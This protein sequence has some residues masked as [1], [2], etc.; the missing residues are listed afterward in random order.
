[1]TT[2]PSKPFWMVY[3]IRQGAPT[4]MH[5]THEK[6]RDEAK[7]LA[8]NNPGV[9]FVVLE[10]VGAVVKREFDTVSFRAPKPTSL[11]DDDIPF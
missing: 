5:D 11:T 3:G 7:R 4:V 1:M 2:L 8:R 6:A 10:S 9:V